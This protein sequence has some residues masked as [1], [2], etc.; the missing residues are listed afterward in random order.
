MDYLQPATVNKGKKPMAAE[1]C[2]RSVVWAKTRT[3]KHL[4]L[5]VCLINV[6]RAQA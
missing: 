1:N 6:I 4:L 2:G 5:S 3:S